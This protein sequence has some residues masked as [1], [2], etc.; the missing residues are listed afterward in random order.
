MSDHVGNE[1]NACDGQAG[2]TRSLP[3]VDGLREEMDRALQAGAGPKLARFALACLGGVPFVGGALGGAAGFW[4]EAEQARLNKLFAAWLKFQEQELRE[5]GVT[6]MEVMARLD[7]NDPEIQKRIES[8]EYLSLVRKCFRDWSAAESEEKRQLI[9]NLLCN[10]AAFKL[11]KDEVVKLFIKWIEDYSEA[12]FAVIREV[13]K[14]PGST[15]RDIWRHIHGAEVREDSAEADLFRLLVHDLSVGRVVR[16]HREKDYQGNFLKERSKR[17][18]A[19]PSRVMT[20]A[21]E[22]D[23]EYELTELGKQF[24]HYTMNEIVPKLAAPST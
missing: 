8:P 7:T 24:V 19:R 18:P 16:Q 23:K 20:S 6:L 22:D 13:Y 21:F 14:H 3:S 4:S 11:A 17:S 15:R 9:R 2:D 5:I 1:D 12:H 10:A